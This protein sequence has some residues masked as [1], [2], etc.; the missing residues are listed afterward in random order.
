MQDLVKNVTKISYFL[1][2]ARK[3]WDGQHVPVTKDQALALP[4]MPGIWLDPDRALF[5]EPSRSLVLADLHLGFEWVQRARGQLLPLG[6]PQDARERIQLLVARWGARR[7][8]VLGDM[9]HGN[10]GL[11]GVR[12]SLEDLLRGI[13]GLEWRVVLGN[14]DRGLAGRLGQ[15]AIPGVS[16]GGEWREP[17]WLGVHGDVV[18]DP[19]EGERV[20]S[21]HEH[22]AVDVGR[23][24]TGVVR[25]PA[26]VV[27]PRG[28]ILPAFSPWA[29]GSEVG[30]RPPLGEWARR[31]GATTY[32]AC[33][34]ARLL[35]IPAE[36]L[37]A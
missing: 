4:G 24:G 8:V 10:A 21:G 14:H 35:P 30:R 22:P 28:V 31:L 33:M 13:P 1:G 27:G 16:W 29:A 25:V 7:V 6:R 36:R 5:H 12:R 32:V 19:G 9:V 2:L 3:T 20:L 11:D 15:W 18:P 34:G 26:F 23:P 37:G 17:G